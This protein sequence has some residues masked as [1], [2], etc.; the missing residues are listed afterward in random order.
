MFI[1]INYFNNSNKALEYVDKRVDGSGIEVIASECVTSKK[2]FEA[3]AA[4]RPGLLFNTVVIKLD[5]G[6]KNSEDVYDNRHDLLLD[7]MNRLA[8][9]GVYF[10]QFVIV[11]SQKFGAN[12][13]YYVVAS[14]VDQGGYNVDI[15]HLSSKAGEASIIFQLMNDL[16]ADACTVAGDAPNL[17]MSL[18]DVKSKSIRY[19]GLNPL[20][21]EL[22][23]PFREGILYSLK[24]QLFAC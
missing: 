3:R 4:M 19:G 6:S 1:E 8:G 5:F 23:R 9:C 10:D 16:T 11:H 22:V 2:D 14:L 21:H 15:R 17:P 24:K 12:H 7:W 18:C 13:E 20:N